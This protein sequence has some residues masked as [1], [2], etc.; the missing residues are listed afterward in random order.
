MDHGDGRLD[1][2]GHGGERNFDL[3]VVGMGNLGRG[4]HFLELA[5]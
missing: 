1:H 3:L 4:V 2:F 5:G